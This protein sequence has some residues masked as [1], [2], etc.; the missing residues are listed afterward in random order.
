MPFLLFSESLF[1]KCLLY[2]PG[3][4]TEL[5]FH[6]HHPGLGLL[7]VCRA[8]RVR[9]AAVV[10]RRRWRESLN[11]MVQLLLKSDEIIPKPCLC[12]EETCLTVKCHVL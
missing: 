9:V 6:V 11:M 1:V 5:S 4:L 2:H 3:K 12:I 8:R 10:V 7:S